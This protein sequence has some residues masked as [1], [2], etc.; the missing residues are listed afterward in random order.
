MD[1]VFALE[2]RRRNWLALFLCLATIS[3]PVAAAGGENE[4]DEAAPHEQEIVLR[5]ADEVAPLL[6]D[7]FQDRE[8]WDSL[9]ERL[10]LAARDTCG[11]KC[12]ALQIR[13]V[14]QKYLRKQRKHDAGFGY[15]AVGGFALLLERRI[16]DDASLDE[17]REKNPWEM[18][19]GPFG[20]LRLGDGAAREPYIGRT[21]S[22]ISIGVPAMQNGRFVGAVYLHFPL[23]RAAADDV[24]SPDPPQS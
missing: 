8:C 1:Y 20:D 15:V 18:Y 12:I 4:V 7:Y 13:R 6:Q 10:D 16:E 3:F 5:L 19:K 9:T 24:G 23:P 21:T 2:S 14:L 22:W 11:S 17:W